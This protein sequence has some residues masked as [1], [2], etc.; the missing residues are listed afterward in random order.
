M[1][2]LQAG[3]QA[4]GQGKARRGRAQQATPDPYTGTNLT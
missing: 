3:R 4:G 1:E 2:R